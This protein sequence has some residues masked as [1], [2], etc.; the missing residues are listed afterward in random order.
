M[1]QEIKL[2]VTDLD[3]TFLNEDKKVSAA[4]KQAIASCRQKGM[5]FAIASGRPL[6]PVLEL[7][8]EWGIE[9]HCDYVLAM[10]GAEIFD[11][12]T[13]DKESFYQ[14]PA[15]VIKNI[16]KHY[17]NM[18]VRFYL[19]D[20]NIRYVN[21]SDDET[22]K[23]AEVFGEIEV[24]TD[25]FA[26]CSRPFTKLIVECDPEDMSIVEKHGQ[27]YQNDS[28]TCFKSAPNLFE[29]V[30]PRVNKSYGLKQLCERKGFSMKEVLAFGDTSNDVEMLKDAGVG[31]WMSNGTQDA[32][33]VANAYTLTNEED[34]VA[35]YLNTHIL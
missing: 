31:V 2:I 28:C 27:E 6:E 35:V 20:K 21:Y 5:Q 26:L 29:F 4:N 3:G 11:C 24:Q 7:M 10:N 25:M 32:K 30:D 14:L 16:M 12:H 17:E 13:K 34:G 22:K 8:K 18:N 23:A 1:K 9:E 33:E 15:D 19:F